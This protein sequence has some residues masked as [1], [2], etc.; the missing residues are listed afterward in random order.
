[1][2]PTVEDIEAWLGQPLPEPYRSFLAA[3]AEYRSESISTLIYGRESIQE[4]NETYECREYLP[5]H[6]MIG[7]DSGGSAIVLSLATGELH[8]IGMGAMTE[9]FFEPV[10]SEFAAWEASGFGLP[11]D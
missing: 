5:G 3:T 2:T 1:M 7:D 10:A 9:E 6:L 4:R 8:R 11:A